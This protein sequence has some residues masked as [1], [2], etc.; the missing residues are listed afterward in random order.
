MLDKASYR[1]IPDVENSN[2]ESFEITSHPRKRNESFLRFYSIAISATLLCFAL[3]FYNSIPTE[4]SLHQGVMWSV[5]EQPFSTKG[6]SNFI[7]LL[8]LI[9]FRSTKHR[10]F[11]Y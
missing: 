5:L 7:F 8:C 4:E 11:K 2:E 3:L 6:G 1:R 10:I 9:S